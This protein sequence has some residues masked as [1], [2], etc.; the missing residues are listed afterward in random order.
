MRRNLSNGLE[1]LGIQQAEVAYQLTPAELVEEALKNGEGTLAD[2]GALAVDTGKFTG[3]SPK[4]RFV[5]E[6]NPQAGERNQAEYA[7]QPE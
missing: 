5:V 7:D 2:S 6:D 4:D 1:Y 3:R